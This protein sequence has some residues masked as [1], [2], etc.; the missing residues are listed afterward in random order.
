MMF[1]RYMCSNREREIYNT[2]KVKQNQLSFGKLIFRYP[3]STHHITIKMCVAI[4]VFI[5]ESASVY[6]HTLTKPVSV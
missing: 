3:K 5:C 6:M 4:Y 2:C 1:S